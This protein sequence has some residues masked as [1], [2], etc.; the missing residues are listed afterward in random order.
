MKH[1]KKSFLVL[2]TIAMLLLNTILPPATPLP[3]PESDVPNSIQD[4]INQDETNY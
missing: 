2:L 4:I 1:P 3:K